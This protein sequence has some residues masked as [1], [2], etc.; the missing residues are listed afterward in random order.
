MSEIP[1]TINFESN[2]VQIIDQISDT[3]IDKSFECTNNEYTEYYQFQSLYDL[4]ENLARTK[5][6]TYKGKVIG[7]ISIAMA[8]MEKERS[9]ITM[10][11]ATDGNI[12]ALLISYLA[13]HKNYRRRGV[14]TRL[15]DEAVRIATETSKEIGCRYVML[16]PE[17][18]DGV[19]KFYSEYGFTHI[20]HE[21]KKRV[22]FILDIK[23]EKKQVN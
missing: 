6:L 12:P 13:T 19:R 9:E 8:H 10:G 14:G 23:T 22:A 20:P 16:S 17:D 21:D 7:Y 15:V 3:P 5:L 2:D 1:E 18:D 4:Q 11:K